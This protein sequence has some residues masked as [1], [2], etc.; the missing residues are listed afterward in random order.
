MPRRDPLSVA[1]D[2]QTSAFIDRVTH[3]PV[4]GAVLVR[5]GFVSR[6]GVVSTS[7]FVQ[8]PPG[9]QDAY[10]A[11]FARSLHYNFRAEF[12]PPGR[13][14]TGARQPSPVWLHLE[15]RGRARSGIYGVVRIGPASARPWISGEESYVDNPALRY[16]GAGM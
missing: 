4:V 7:I 5:G 12:T 9:Q 15:W 3:D 8:Y 1:Y 13:T 16:A 11:A 14:S 2:G 6:T 10:L